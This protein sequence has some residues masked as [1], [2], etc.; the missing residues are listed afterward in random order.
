ML[1]V[2]VRRG[3][4]SFVDS[5]VAPRIRKS[6]VLEG[7]D[8]AVINIPGIDQPYKRIFYSN[9]SRWVLSRFVSRRTKILAAFSVICIA[10][11]QPCEQ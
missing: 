10:I 2:G 4:I 7:L 8:D 5:L 9:E 11:S 1:L 6:E 3:E